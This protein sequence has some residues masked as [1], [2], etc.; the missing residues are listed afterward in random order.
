MNPYKFIILT[1]LLLCI[2][3]TSSCPKGGNTNQ[4]SSAIIFVG[5]TPCDKTIQSML[6]IPSGKKI[7]FIRWNLP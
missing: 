2:L 4:S 6:R 3:L 1:G 5:S 7:D